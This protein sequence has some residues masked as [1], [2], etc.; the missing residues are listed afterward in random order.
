[1]TT[2]EILSNL[3]QEDPDTNVFEYILEDGEE[4]TLS[5]LKTLNHLGYVY[6]SEQTEI[7]YE[8]QLDDDTLVTKY[9]S[10]YYF[11][12]HAQPIHENQIPT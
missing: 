9:M 7:D 1:M 10:I 11:A 8:D 2:K 6:H 12:R 3:Y 5:E 4:L